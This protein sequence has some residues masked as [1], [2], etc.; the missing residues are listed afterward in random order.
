[1]LNLFD[2][3]CRLL[4]FGLLP[5]HF[6]S[7]NFINLDIFQGKL[8][9]NLFARS[10]QYNA[11]YYLPRSDNA[12][13][14]LTSHIPH[15]TP[16]QTIT[17]L[18]SSLEIIESMLMNASNLDCPRFTY[19]TEFECLDS[20]PMANP[21]KPLALGYIYVDTQSLSHSPSRTITNSMLRLRL[22]KTLTKC[23]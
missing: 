19:T 5:F 10:W 17:C 16:R 11:L 14:E 18:A 23:K 12:T 13:E 9:I 3:T 8:P 6:L 2:F 7:A 1:M 22:C 21:S 20:L 15:F 4:H